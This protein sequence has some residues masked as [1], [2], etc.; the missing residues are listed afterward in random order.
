MDPVPSPARAPHR[1]RRGGVR[2]GRGYTLVELVVVMTVVGVLAAVM[3]PRFFSQ[4]TFAQRGYADEL[5]AALR[6]TQKVAVASGC[7]AQLTLSAT[8]FAAAQQA[9]AGNTCN[10]ADTGFSTAVI[11]ADGQP[12]RDSAPAEVS[13]SPTGSYLFDAQGRLASSPGTL[14]TVGARSIT[15]AATTGLVLVQ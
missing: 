8:G 15:L 7:P 2:R 9:A 12:L 5:A 1:R 4:Q 10:P 11:G 6:A 14:I 3:G 13:V